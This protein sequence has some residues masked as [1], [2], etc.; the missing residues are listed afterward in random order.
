MADPISGPVVCVVGATGFIGRAVIEELTRTD[1]TV[2]TTHAPRLHTAARTAPQI[3]EHACQLNLEI[4]EGTTAII[5]AAGAASP[6]ASDTDG[7][8]GA[9][10]LL[11]A[12]LAIGARSEA[13]PRLVHISSAAVQGYA[14][15]LTAEPLWQPHSPYAH[16]KSLGEQAILSLFV[17]GAVIHR[18]TSVH[19]P[20][21]AV[22]QKLSSIASG[23]LASVAGNGDGPTPQV[24]VSQV[25]QAVSFLALSAEHL[26][27]I[28]LQP[29]GGHTVTSILEQLG[30][31]AP[32]HIPPRLAGAITG[33]GRRPAIGRLRPGLAGQARRLEMMW[34]GQE[35]E[36]GWLDEVRPDL[37]ERSPLWP[38]LR[39]NA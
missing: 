8:Y 9:N 39:R 11:P 25:A 37:S 32:R 12:A 26:P 24:H 21:R 28:T 1:V 6:T 33:A 2:V 15:V 30:G 34:F 19:G 17:P 4:P 5:N 23:P 10:A 16:S 13:V 38:E 27:S 31:R 20:G 35:Q 29:W 36:P 18:A 3:L 14:R 7:L 22:T